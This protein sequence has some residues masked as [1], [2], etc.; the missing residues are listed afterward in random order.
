MNIPYEN[1]AVLKQ[2]IEKING[3]IVMMS[4]RPAINHNR[5]SGNIFSEFRTYLKGK[6]C[7]A[8][9]DGVDVFLDENNHFIPD[10]M[11]VCNKDIIKIDAIYGAP[12][13]V[14]EVLS[15][16]TARNDR[17]RKKRV[18]EKVGVKEYWI[19]EPVYKTVEVY[20]NTENGFVLDHVYEYYTD[21]EIAENAK[22]ADDDENKI[23]DIQSSIKVRICDNLDVN[24]EDIFS[25]VS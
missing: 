6:S 12:D 15:P 17:T 20:I 22:L 16:S 14:V 9:S 1:D 10:V 25:N 21:E 13:L 23:H 7:E 11:I 4:P 19:V 24:L 18:Y 5:V 2:R 3:K 8:F